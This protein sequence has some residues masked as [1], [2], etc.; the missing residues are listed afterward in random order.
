MEVGFKCQDIYRRALI[1]ENSYTAQ[2]F[3]TIFNC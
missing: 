3:S 1:T 2:Q